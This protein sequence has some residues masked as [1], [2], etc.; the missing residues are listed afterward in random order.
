[1]PSHPAISFGPDKYT[2]MVSKTKGCG[3][4]R[5]FLNASFPFWMRKNLQIIQAYVEK[6]KPAG[7]LDANCKGSYK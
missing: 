1:M 6:Q 5:F 7:T 2:I 4:W 3:R